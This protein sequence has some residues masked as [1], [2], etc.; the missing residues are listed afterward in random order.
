MERYRDAYPAIAGTPVSGRGTSWRQ[1]G[2]WK[3]VEAAAR[4]AVETGMPQ[5]AGRCRFARDSDA[6]VITLPSGRRLHYRNARVEPRV[7]PYCQALGLEP[8]EKPTL[9]Y[10]GPKHVGI[11][12]YGGKLVENV[13]QA[14]CRDLLV[15]AMLAC[16][17]AGLTV[18]QHVHDEL[19]VEV[20]GRPGRGIAAAVGGDHVHAA[21]LGRGVPG[22]GGGVCL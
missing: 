15:A 9:V 14:L 2:L 10:D 3:E 4:Q 22:R 1:G 20:A 21:G 8:K 6:L 17:Q 5:A 18:V 12:T 7:P 19:V 13:V 16:E 11:T